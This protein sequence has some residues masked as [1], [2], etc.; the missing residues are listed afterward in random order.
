MVTITLYARQQKRHGCCA[1][2]KM[3]LAC[4]ILEAVGL[5]QIFLIYR[6]RQ[7]FNYFKSISVRLLVT[8][9]LF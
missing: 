4:T 3:T 9:F 2:L 1:T 7:P 5:T 8:L 6:V